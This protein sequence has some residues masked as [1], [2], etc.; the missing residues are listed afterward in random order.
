[1]SDNPGNREA[2]RDYI[3]GS[4]STL[5]RRDLAALGVFRTLVMAP[6]AYSPT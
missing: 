3:A 5:P 6:G 1:M 4:W 2:L